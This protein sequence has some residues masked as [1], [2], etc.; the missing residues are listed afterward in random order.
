[1]GCPCHIAHNAASKATKAFVK[2]VDDF[3]IEELL[4]DIYFHFDYSSKRKNLFV[5]FCEFC[6]QEYS[7]ILN[8]HSVRWLGMSTCI[9]RVLKLFPLLKSYFLSL[10]PEIKK[11][12][13]LKTRKNRLINAFKH[14]LLN[15]LLMFL[16]S[17]LP[18]LIQLNLQRVD[19]LIHILYASL[20]SCTSLLLSRFEQPD[21]VREYQR[22]EVSFDD[23]KN[24]VMNDDN[25]LENERLFVGI[26]VRGKINTLFEDGTITER[27]VKNFHTACLEFHLTAFLYAINNFPLKDEFLKHVRFLNFY[28]QKCSFESVLF[29]VEKLKH[30]LQFSPQQLN[31]LEQEVSIASIY[32]VGGHAPRSIRRSSYSY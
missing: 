3:D 26:F 17:I 24:E 4:V 21:L 30:F 23:I 11:G 12:V 22:G 32:S 2:I 25:I 14:P 7:K 5:E 28:D 27:Q 19:P 15:E 10:N 6:D 31:E 8:F 20:F 16:D 13:E 9:E 1:M 29:T 18:P